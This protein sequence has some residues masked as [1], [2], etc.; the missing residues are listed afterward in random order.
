[1]AIIQDFFSELNRDE[2]TYMH[3]KSNTDLKRNFDGISDF[4]V[5]VSDEDYEHLESILTQFGARRFE[6]IKEKRYPYV[7]SWLLYDS[8]SGKLYHIHLHRRLM[9]GKEY[10]K[11]YIIP[12]HDFLLNTRIFDSIWNIYITEPNVE[13]ILLATRTVIKS[14]SHDLRNAKN[15]KYQLPDKLNKIRQ[16]LQ[17]KMNID[18]LKYYCELL[19]PNQDSTSIID[20]GLDKEIDS[21]LFLKLSNLI[22]N[23]LKKDRRMS[24]LSAEIKFR[25]HSFSYKVKRHLAR[26]YDANII[27]KKVL[28]NHRGLIVALVGVDGAGK[29]TSAKNLAKWLG[30][31]IDSKN[32]FMGE[33]SGKTGRLVAMLI[34][35]IRI[36]DTSAT[37]AS[38]NVPE[39]TRG[40]EVHRRTN[41]GRKIRTKLKSFFKKPQI[42]TI[43]RA[44]IIVLVQQRNQ[45]LLKKMVRYRNKG[46]I[47][48]TDRYPQM[49][50][51]GMNDGLKV[52]S[53]LK[54]YPSSFVL[55]LFQQLEKKYVRKS[56][57]IKPDVVFRLNIS[58]QTSM[59]RKPEQKNIEVYKQ[60][61]DKL[62]DIT[63]NNSYI[64]DINAEQP[65]DEELLLLKRNIWTLLI[66]HKDAKQSVL[67]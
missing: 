31:Q 8:V 16:V 25:I 41:L 63:F 39:E 13:L 6:T 34:R 18:K 36:G 50:S 42:R 61:L 4:D 21:E 22:R 57:Q 1:M 30:Y 29:S 9:S 47:S 53:Y 44:L 2:V 48:I 56:V 52:E 64:I 51:P 19:F 15:G 59:E 37:N 62:Q 35:I 43:L 40:V 54:K 65:Y 27:T 12:W 46:G 26:K 38:K 67:L 10:V 7:C 55:K 3:F 23:S 49:E 11:D 60:K 58:I 28:E 66:K 32:Y 14:K 24:P 20:F 45:R 17:K 33:G 5:L